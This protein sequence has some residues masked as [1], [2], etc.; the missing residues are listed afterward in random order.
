VLGRVSGALLTDSIQAALGSALAR[1]GTRGRTAAHTHSLVSAVEGLAGGL[2]QD[3]TLLRPLL[4][5]VDAQHTL[6]APDAALAARL[7]R[8]GGRRLALFVGRLIPG[9]G[10]QSLVAAL[11]LVARSVCARVA[12]LSRLTRRCRAAR[13]SL[14]VVGHGPMRGVLEVGLSVSRLPLSPAQPKLT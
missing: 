7:G 11:P 4:Q 6:T 2:A 13:L 5:R 8:L 12:W 14:V 10:V 3:A 1:A 9:K